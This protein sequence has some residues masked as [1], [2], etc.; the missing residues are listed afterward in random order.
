MP[1]FLQ[2][3]LEALER[4]YRQM[5]GGSGGILVVPVPVSHN[6]EVGQWDTNMGA[7]D[8]S[9]PVSPQNELAGLNLMAPAKPSM[10]TSANLPAYNASGK[11]DSSGSSGTSGLDSLQ[12][13]FQSLYGGG[14]PN[15]SGYVPP[16]N[17]N[18]GGVWYGN[19][20]QLQVGPDVPMGAPL[21]A[22]PISENPEVG[23]GLSGLF[24]GGGGGGGGLLSGSQAQSLGSGIG[25]L[26]S[27]FYKNQPNFQF[28]NPNVGQVS[29]AYFMPPSLSPNT[30]GLLPYTV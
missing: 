23:Q 18:P 20:G 25:G 13:F 6:P 2:N 4:G 22:T 28:S 3:S 14:G 1:T 5:Y 12:K 27:N 8:P 30:G 15:L 11:S 9:A 29:P 16:M 10:A 24:G 21:G 26:I 7:A 17:A 19:P